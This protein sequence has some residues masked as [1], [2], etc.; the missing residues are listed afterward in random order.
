MNIDRIFEAFEHQ[1]VL[2]VGDVMLDKYFIGNVDRI[3]PEAPV[4]IVAVNKT[5]SR[6]GGA[7]NVALNLKNLGAKVVLASVIGNDEN[8]RLLNQLC[9]NHMID[10][11]GFVKSEQRITTS[12]TRVISRGQQVLRYDIE[13]KH[14]INEND[15]TNLIEKIKKLISGQNITLII[16]QD[17]NK[18]I[19]TAQII[20]AVIKIAQ[21]NNIKVAVDP[22]K[23]NFNSYKNATLFKPNL[24]ELREGLN[25]KIDPANISELLNANKLLKETLDNQYTLITLSEHGVF[26]VGEGHYTEKA[27]LRNIADVSGAGDTVISVAGLVLAVTSNIHMVAKLSNLAGGLVCESVGVVPIDRE[28]LLAEAKK[29]KITS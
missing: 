28:R 6:L 21:D 13:D 26:I 20:K 16:L 12:K 3:S 23:D 15:E 25:L 10:T 14:D 17:Y 27:H 2:V 29:L 9:I 4:P 5:E 1:N 18:G 11:A 24:K 22:K 19:L 7:A 8:G